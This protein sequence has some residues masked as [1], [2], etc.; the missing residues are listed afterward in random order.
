MEPNVAG[1][2]I[3]EHAKDFD[4]GNVVVRVTKLVQERP[5]YSMQLL[6]RC[7]DGKMQRHFGV[8]IAFGD[9]LPTVKD[10]IA[11]TVSNLI[12]EAERWVEQQVR[13]FNTEL[14]K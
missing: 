6:R 8:F 3:W 7:N 10:S 5:R 9:G 4:K 2:K 13:N 12:A 1:A 11:E 14:Q